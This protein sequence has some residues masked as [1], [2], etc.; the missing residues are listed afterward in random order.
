MQKLSAVTSDKVKHQVINLAHHE[1]VQ[2]END[3]VIMVLV[4][5][6]SLPVWYMSVLQLFRPTKGKTPGAAQPMQ[7][8]ISNFLVT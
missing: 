3:N 5:G 7:T 4:N 2:D 6:F 8:F 1:N